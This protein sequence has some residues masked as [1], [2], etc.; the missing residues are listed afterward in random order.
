MEELAGLGA[1]VHTCSIDEAEVNECLKDWKSKDLP[2]TASVCDVSSRPQREELIETVSSMF[3][4]KL[5]FL[6]S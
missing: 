6:V 1:T 5:N 3:N 2:I 4:G